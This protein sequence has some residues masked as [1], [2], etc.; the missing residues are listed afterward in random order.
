MWPCILGTLFRLPWVHWQNSHGFNRCNFRTKIWHITARDNKQGERRRDG[1]IRWQQCNSEGLWAVLIVMNTSFLI[2]CLFCFLFLSADCLF[3][4]KQVC[5][6]DGHWFFASVA[7]SAEQEGLGKVCKRS[8]EVMRGIQ[9]GF[10][11]NTIFL[12]LMKFPAQ[13]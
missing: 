8:N 11:N 2:F 7:G 13:C 12:F 4:P 10:R 1:R 6:G 5:W 9:N 3:F